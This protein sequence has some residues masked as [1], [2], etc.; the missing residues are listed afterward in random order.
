[1]DGRLGNARATSG[2]EAHEP[3]TH[4]TPSS[5]FSVVEPI[6]TSDSTKTR[7]PLPRPPGDGSGRRAL[8]RRLILG[9]VVCQQRRQQSIERGQRLV[10]FARL[11]RAAL[12]VAPYDL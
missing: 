7:N 3:L 2:A 10:E 1:M 9:L 5:V 12:A 6:S 4:S 11:H 8:G